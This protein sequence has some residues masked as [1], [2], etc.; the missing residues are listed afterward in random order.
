MKI[1]LTQGILLVYLIL[2]SVIT[3]DINPIVWVLFIGVFIL[4]NLF[5][6]NE[7]F[8]S[9][10]NMAY[11][12]IAFV[13][14]INLLLLFLIYLPYAVFGILLEKRSFIKSY[15]LGFAVSLIPTILLYTAS[16]YFSLKLNVI[17]IFSVFYLPVAAGII[18]M[19]YKK[20][21]HNF[22]GVD[23]KD[24]LVIIVALASAVFIALSIVND[25]S[26]FTSNS[27]Y[28]YSKFDL[29]VKSIHSSGDF[30]IYDPSTSS[31]E[32]PFLFE[33]PLFFSHLAFANILLSFI[34]PVTFFNL[35]TLFI[36]FL[37]T[38]S[39]SL[40]LRS[41]V[42]YEPGSNSISYIAVI[43]LGSLSAGFNFYF[44]QYLEAFKEFFM[45]PVN[46]LIFS[47]ILEKPGK[48]KE[49]ALIS[50]MV[51]L[52]FITH[53]S[54]G[55]GILLMSFSL[56]LL[57]LIKML[58]KGGWGDI[59]GWIC[60]NKIKIMAIGIC[61]IFL[62]LFYIAPTFIFKD[63]LEAKGSIKLEG[64][65]SRSFTYV[66]DFVTT[67][68]P[69]SL[70]YPDVNRNDDKK[71]GPFISVFG[72]AALAVLLVLFKV[73]SLGNL[74]LFFGAYCLHILIS[75]VIM[76]HPMIGSLEYAYRTAAPYLLIIL[77][78][79]IC[80]FILL[81]NQKYVKYG[82]MLI[83]LASLVY[84]LP[85][86]RQNLGNI[87]REEFI[88]GNGFQNEINVAKSLP[89]DGRIITYGLFANTIDPGMAVLTDKYYSRYHLTEYARSRS[90][91][92][93]IH[94]TNS[95][96]QEDFVLNKSGTELSNYLRI[97]GYKYIFTN[98]CNPVGNFIINSL[99]PNFT[100]PIYQ[101]QE[102]QCLVFLMVNGTNYAE[103]VSVLE[104]VDEE[105]YKNKEGYKYYSLSKHFDFGANIP[106]SKEVIEP[107]GLDFKRKTPTEVI[108]SGDFKNNDWVVFK[109]DYFSR[110]KAYMNNKE[111]PILATN[112]NSI[113]M[114]TVKGSSITLK[115]G[116]LPIER[117]I[118]AISFMAAL[119]LLVTFLIFLIKS[120]D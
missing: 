93:I 43:I 32:S 44:I 118:G 34:P 38:I 64:S 11:V 79:S 88:S 47:L 120:E 23:F 77:S 87:H 27:T 42:P 109:E 104:N 17:V 78:A 58:F 55:V 28:V 56:V 10:E 1:K 61:M 24:Y 9:I 102:N 33:T 112:H 41:I 3:K 46:Y 63:F 105:V 116:V 45:F 48:F 74:R 18:F 66:K 39:L 110:W 57:I 65:L 67:E 95:F 69:V 96:G 81:I 82:L 99:Y 84:A 8:S 62:P 60:K 51:L 5:G 6:K 2:I 85:L 54:H 26:L 113:L 107:E 72:L 14:F 80:A 73:K 21:H 37:S 86:A 13:P 106:Y 97:G 111:I 76:N 35:Y 90:I 19:F 83:L 70:H 36:L 53:T 59:K 91:Y 20:K 12:L 52:S 101:N 98:I 40:L 15:I 68:A 103:K 71:F 75:A 30:P 29:I 49:I 114:K 25:Y 115:Y 100:S 22:L 117:I 94:G 92:W 119:L 50:Y 31:G 89:N 7:V 16:N 108:I 4:A